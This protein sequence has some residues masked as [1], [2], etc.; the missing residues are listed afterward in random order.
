MVEINK[1]TDQIKAIAQELVNEEGLDFDIYRL[2]HPPSKGCQVKQETG[3]KTR[4]VEL[5]VS[6]GYSAK[7][8]VCGVH[9][10]SSGWIHVDY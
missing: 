10:T 2:A 5:G 6:E 4:I 3:L 9:K 7:R 1:L 8:L